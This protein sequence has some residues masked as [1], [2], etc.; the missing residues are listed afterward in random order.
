M[1]RLTFAVTVASFVLFTST[2]AL[3]QTTAQI[4]LQFD[5]MNPGARSLSL[6]GAFIGA[7]DDATAAFA[8]PAGLAFLTTRE[9]SAEG[10]F[11]RVETRFFEGGRINGVP[12][13]RGADTV[14]HPVYG[15][16]VDREL[17]PAFLSFVMPFDRITVAAYRHEVATIDNSFLSLGA[18]ERVTFNGS[19]DDANRDTAIGGKRTI[20]IRNYGAAIAYKVHDRLAVGG[21]VS[22]YTF[23]LR[24]D[25]ARFGL[26]SDVFGDIDR[27]RIGATATQRGSDASVA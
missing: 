9:A 3:A 5:F 19:T 13:G 10:R 20:A 7:A 1:K 23:D 18:F 25:F 21:G 14:D 4:P 15:T 22:V 2:S 27:N 17:G 16:D 11:R 24:S 12:T 8:N 26:V 6:G